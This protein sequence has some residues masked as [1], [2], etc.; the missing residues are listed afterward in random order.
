MHASVLFGVHIEEGHSAATKGFTSKD[1]K[2]EI[3]TL[4]HCHCDCNCNLNFSEVLHN[5]Y[6]YLFHFCNIPDIC[7]H[8]WAK[9]ISNI[10]YVTGPA[11]INHLSAKNR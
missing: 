8:D 6:S 2:M 4:F 3:Q 1:S 5:S 9:V 7:M 11:K 10:K